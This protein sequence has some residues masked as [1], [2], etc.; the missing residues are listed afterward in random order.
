MDLW[1][2]PLLERVDSYWG[3]RDRTFTREFTAGRP[4]LLVIHSGSTSNWTAEYL[5]NPVTKEPNKGRLCKDGKRRI[6]AAAHICF[7]EGRVEKLHPEVAW[8]AVS[9]TFVQTAPLNLDIPGAGGSMCQGRRDVNRRAIHIELPAAPED[10]LVIK[11][12]FQLVLGP[13]KTRCP[14]LRFWTAHRTIDPENKTDPVPGTGFDKSWLDG[15][16]LEFA[17]RK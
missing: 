7:Y 14:N 13:L 12:L 10:P 8:P 16:E 5:S 9:N 17:P 1:L 2:Y 11:A 15:F 6:V 4:D 3:S